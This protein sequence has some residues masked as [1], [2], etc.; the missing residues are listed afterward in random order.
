MV[1]VT[2]PLKQGCWLAL[3][4]GD[5]RRVTFKW[6]RVSDFCFIY[7][8]L[9][10][11]ESDCKTVIKMELN[12]ESV[13]KSYNVILRANGIQIQNKRDGKPSSLMS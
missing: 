7:K 1:D 9:N 13:V 3:V 11:L 10:H 12:R 6:E 2:K 4:T 8:C 5:W